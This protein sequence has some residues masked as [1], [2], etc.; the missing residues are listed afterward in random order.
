MSY[1][2]DKEDFCEATHLPT[3]GKIPCQQNKRDKS[4]KGVRLKSLTNPDYDAL[5]TQLRQGL[6]RTTSAHGLIAMCKHFPP[7]HGLTVYIPKE[8]HLPEARNCLILYQE[9]KMDDLEINL[10]VTTGESHE[11]IEYVSQD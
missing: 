3:T 9:E 11:E 1:C 7:M 6:P 4:I 5:E 2:K 10:T 8:G